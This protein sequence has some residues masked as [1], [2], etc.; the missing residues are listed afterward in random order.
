M[1]ECR[2]EEEEKEEV[3]RVALM[4]ERKKRMT[5]GDIGKGED[6]KIKDR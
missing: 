5:R 6:G 1:E 2:E 3:S 4:Q